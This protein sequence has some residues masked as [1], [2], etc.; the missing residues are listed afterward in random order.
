MP[1]KKEPDGRRSVEAQTEVFG[2]PEQVWQAIATGPGISSWFVPS[3]I[4]ERAG[5]ATFSTFGLG[6]DSHGKIAEW[7][8][9]HRYVVSTEEGPGEVASEWTVEAQAGGVCKVRVVHSWFASKDDWDGQ[10]EGH[11]F[12]WISFF[13]ILQRYMQHFAGQ[14]SSIIALSPMTTEPDPWG[15]LVRPLGLNKAVPRQICS[16]PPDIPELSGLVEVVNPPEW[17]GL[18]LRLEKPAP[19]L[20]HLFAMPMGPQTLLSIRFY[21]YGPEGAAAA[22]DVEAKWNAWLATIFPK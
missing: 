3:Q 8:P 1:V 16:T 17:P 12:G 22:N 2:T 10:F 11:S 4:E 19:A 13:Q 15:R 5:G 6:M 7:Q 20:A 18:L 21:L 14:P 9:P